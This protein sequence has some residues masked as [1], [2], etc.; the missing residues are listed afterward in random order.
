MPSP[1]E[2]LMNAVQI[3][4]W[5]G[6]EQLIQR[7]LPRPV[8]GPGQ[9]LVR[10][11]SASLNAVDR[12]VR[13]G[14]MDGQLPLP[15]TGGSDFSGVVEATGDGADLPPGTAVFGALWPT[16][17]AYAEYTVFDAADLARKPEQLGFDE[18]AALPVA[19]ITARVAVLDDGRVRQGQRVLIQGAAG[20]VGHLA[21][22]LAKKQGAHVIAT[23]SRANH[24]FVR[25]LGADEVIDY[26]EPGYTARLGGLDLV[27]DGVSSANLSALYPAIRPGGLAISLFDPPTPPPDGIEARL[28]GTIAIAQQPLRAPLEA[29]SRLVTEGTLHVAVTASYPLGKIAIAQESGVRGKAVVRP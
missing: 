27:I 22:Q 26:R 2:P 10:V 11:R 23:A 13:Q 25:T 17:G 7:R 19:G 20:G 4:A 15:Y 12:R 8:P 21:V 18:A 16:S 5:G 28:V 29:L 6:P 9:V 1:A 14:Y 24:D 3:D